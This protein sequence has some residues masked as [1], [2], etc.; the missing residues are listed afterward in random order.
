MDRNA[1]LCLMTGTHWRCGANSLIS[2]LDCETLKQIAAYVEKELL[3]YAIADETVLVR[4]QTVGNTFWAAYQYMQDEDP[5][6]HRIIYYGDVERGIDY[7]YRWIQGRLY[8]IM[9]TDLNTTEVLYIRTG[10][11]PS[12]LYGKKEDIYELLKIETHYQM[13]LVNVAYSYMLPEQRF[14]DYD[15]FYTTFKCSLPR[16]KD[17]YIPKVTLIKE[18]ECIRM[19]WGGITLESASLQQILTTTNSFFALFNPEDTPV[20]E[21]RIERI[22]FTN[23]FYTSNAKYITNT[24]VMNTHFFLEQENDE[25]LCK[26]RKI[27]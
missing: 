11:C 9:I 8:S 22:F 7:R 26:K 5:T 27:N 23:C 20:Y 3:V 17:T 24:D 6:L 18:F 4:G 13:K 25:P 21:E 14:I 15:S 19:V 12:L 2:L 16:E 10:K 1:A